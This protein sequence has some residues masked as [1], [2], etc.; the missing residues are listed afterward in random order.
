MIGKFLHEDLIPSDQTLE[1]TV[2]CLEGEEKSQFLGFAR[3]MLKWMPEERGTAKELV[4][5]PWLD[6]GGGKV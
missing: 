3:K 6:L 4:D 5:D 2:T 1:D